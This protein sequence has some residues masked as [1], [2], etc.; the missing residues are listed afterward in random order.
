MVTGSGSEFGLLLLGLK[1]VNIHS[2]LLV[3]ADFLTSKSRNIL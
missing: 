1:Q 3:P 2:Y